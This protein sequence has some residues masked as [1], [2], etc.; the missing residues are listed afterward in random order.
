MIIIDG[1]LLA[2]TVGMDL[3]A[4]H[5]PGA[6]NF[7]VHAGE[8]ETSLM[9]A[10]RPELVNMDKAVCHFSKIHA[11]FAACSCTK[12]PL[13]QQMAAVGMREWKP[14]GEDGVTGD[15]TLATAEKGHQIISRM[16]KELAE[17]F[18]TNLFAASEVSL[19]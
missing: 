4:G 7:D 8:L 15:A 3:L 19:K 17:H 2:R 1:L 9:L 13:L 18:A 16:V 10:V 14:F 6:G 12:G 5:N 11:A